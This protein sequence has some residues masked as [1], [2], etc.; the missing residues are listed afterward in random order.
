[1]DGDGS[2]LSGDSFKIEE[3]KHKGKKGPG[4]SKRYS[5]VWK[6]S[7]VFIY[8]ADEEKMREKIILSVYI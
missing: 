5:P 1:M 6:H 8:G 4:A 3:R 7:H 2:D